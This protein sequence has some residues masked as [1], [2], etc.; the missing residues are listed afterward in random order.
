MARATPLRFV[1]TIVLILSS[2]VQPLA[3]VTITR[4]KEAE[5]RRVLREMRTAID[6]FSAVAKL[7]DVKANDYNLNIPRYVNTFEEAERID[8]NAVALELKEL[9]LKIAE[10]DKVIADFCRELGINTPF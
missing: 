9:D 1:S 4:Q 7:E 5:L 8:I 2:A 6:K 3:K 10:T